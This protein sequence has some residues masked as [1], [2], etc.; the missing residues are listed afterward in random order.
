M[1]EARE[2]VAYRIFHRTVQGEN[3]TRRDFMSNREKG[4]PPRKGE[5]AD[6]TLHGGISVMDTLE[7]ALQRAKDFP[8]HGDYIAEVTIP[9]GSLIVARRTTRTEGHYTL[10]GNAD[11]ILACVTRVI[12]VNAPEEGQV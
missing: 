3:P 9:E 6:P 10:F 2:R 5:I 11:A 8:M 12:Q 4:K 1:D 7:K